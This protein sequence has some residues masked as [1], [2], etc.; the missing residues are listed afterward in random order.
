MPRFRIGRQALRGRTILSTLL[1]A[2]EV[3]LGG[4]L[5][6]TPTGRN[7]FVYTAAT[8]WALL[9]GAL[10]LGTAFHQRIQARREAPKDGR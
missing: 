1:G 10:L 6:L 4:L 9:G 7:R 2:L 5:L 8:I 3:I